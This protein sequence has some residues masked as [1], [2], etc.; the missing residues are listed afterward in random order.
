MGIFDMPNL[1]ID[2]FFLNGHI[3][4]NMTQKKLYR[5]GGGG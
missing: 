4:P 3:L 5:E 2:L 1:Q